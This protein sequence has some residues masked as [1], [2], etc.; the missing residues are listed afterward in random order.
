MPTGHAEMEALATLWEREAMLLGSTLL[1]AEY[2]AG[3]LS[4]QLTY[5]PRRIRVWAT[6]AAA[7]D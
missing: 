5:E 2:G 7:A 1:G 4:T 6:K 3:S